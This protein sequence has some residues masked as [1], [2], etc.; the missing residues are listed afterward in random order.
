MKT[1]SIVLFALVALSSC[2][3]KAKNYTCTCTFISQYGVEQNSGIVNGTN[4]EARDE[5]AKNQEMAQRYYHK[6]GHVTCSLK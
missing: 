3:E 2:K 4:E 6:T 1:I 5:C